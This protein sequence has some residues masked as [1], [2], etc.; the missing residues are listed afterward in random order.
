MLPVVC[1]RMFMRLVRVLVEK[2]MSNEQGAMKRGKR[3]MK[4]EKREDCC[5]RHFIEPDVLM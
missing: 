2:T 3:K 5:L 4:R 1:R